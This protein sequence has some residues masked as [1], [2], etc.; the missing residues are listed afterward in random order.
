[1]LRNPNKKI[2]IIQAKLA[3]SKISKYLNFNGIRK[4]RIK[5]VNIGSG[6]TIK[7]IDFVNKMT[8]KYKKNK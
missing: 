2:D 6:R 8:N 7:V 3:I 4:G 5:V 1:M